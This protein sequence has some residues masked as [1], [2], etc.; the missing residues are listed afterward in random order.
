LHVA[1]RNSD[2]CYAAGGS[3][4]VGRCYNPY[5][6]CTAS[7]GTQS[8]CSDYYAFTPQAVRGGIPDNEI[9]AY[10]RMRGLT[11]GP[12]REATVAAIEDYLRS[13]RK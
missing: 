13:R 10:A 2:D 8:E 1:A 4:G 6:V 11:V 7:V 9:D 3:L 5:A 12:T